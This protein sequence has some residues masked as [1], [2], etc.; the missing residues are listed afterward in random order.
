[1]V[2]PTCTLATGSESKTILKLGDPFS[3]LKQPDLTR[4]EGLEQAEAAGAKARQQGEPPPLHLG[5]T[6][7]LPLCGSY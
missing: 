3:A 1:M 2:G 6:G 7:S 4:A 5:L